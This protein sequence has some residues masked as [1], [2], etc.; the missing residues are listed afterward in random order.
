MSQWAGTQGVRTAVAESR[1]S[2][3]WLYCGGVMVIS[4]DGREVI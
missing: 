2:L 1:G 3:G 4:S